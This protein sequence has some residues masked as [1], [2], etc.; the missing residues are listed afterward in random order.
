MSRKYFGTDG[1]RGRVGQ[2]YA[3]DPGMVAQRRGRARRA[4][5][6]VMGHDLDAARP[7]ILGEDPPDLAVADD[8][9]LPVQ[10][11]AARALR[12]CH[13]PELPAVR[14]QSMYFSPALA[15][16]SRMLYMSRPSTPE[17]SLARLA[18]SFASRAAAASATS[19]A[20]P[21]AC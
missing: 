14:V 11:I 7:Q 21:A 2:A 12:P 3:M 13:C 1:V 15:S 18:A 6:Q 5:L 17:A 19:I 20:M 16:G 8:G 4:E 10:R 9:H